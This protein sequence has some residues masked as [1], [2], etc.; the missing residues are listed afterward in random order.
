MGEMHDKEGIMGLQIRVTSGLYLS[1]TF[2][3]SISSQG[4]A[5]VEAQLR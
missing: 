3:P 1:L 5:A 4:L 2:F